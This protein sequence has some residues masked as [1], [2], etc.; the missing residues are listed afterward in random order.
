MCDGFVLFLCFLV[1]M[2][3]LFSVGKYLEPK[4]WYPYLLAPAASIFVW[5]VY[6]AFARWM[7]WQRENHSWARFVEI[8]FYWF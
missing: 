8:L 4:T 2:F 1:S 5:L 6:D 3:G 7:A